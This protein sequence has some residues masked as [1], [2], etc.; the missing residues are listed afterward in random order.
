MSEAQ[1]ETF[2]V[3]TAEQLRALS[4]PLRQRLLELFTEGATVKQAAARLGSP[5]TRLY[6]HV[7]QLLAAGL[8]RVVREEKRRS[9]TERTFQAAARRFAVSPS[10][11]AA[12]E[13]RL[14]QRERMAR[15]TLEELL[16]GADLGEGAFRLLRTRVRLSEAGRERLEA[17][18][19][20][21]V[22]ELN[23]PAAP[24]VDLMMLSVRQGKP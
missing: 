7:D 8:I 17:E 13:D 2:L 14:S 5:A 6:H 16:A 11:F 1:A 12:G 18:V 19:S 23:D 22:Q 9:V 3:E 15:A 21:L 10:A 20:R 4:D 24:A